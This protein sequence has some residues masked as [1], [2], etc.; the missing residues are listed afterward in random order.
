[1]IFYESP[2]RLLKTLQQF[3]EHFGG[4]R[5]CCVSRELSKKFEENKRGTLTEVFYY[6]QTKGIKGEIVLVV[7]GCKKIKKRT[8]VSDEQ[9]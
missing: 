8:I 5:N 3:I 1:M 2:M 9:E 6:F 4:D 7:E